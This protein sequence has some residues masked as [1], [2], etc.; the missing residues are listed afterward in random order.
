MQPELRTDFQFKILETLVEFRAFF[1]NQIYVGES[2]DHIERFFRQIWCAV[3]WRET[4]KA[5]DESI[6]LATLFRLDPGLLL[7]YDGELKDLRMPLLLKMLARVPPGIIFLPGPR[8]QEPGM[9]WGPQTWL[10]KNNGK[11]TQIEHFLREDQ[12]VPLLED[13]SL[14]VR[15]PGFVLAQAP[16][17]TRNPLLLTTVDLSNFWILQL[18][19]HND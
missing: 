13:G 5:A 9:G 19:D 10:T 7:S 1:A 3:Q 2:K 18:D 15:Y 16:R 17:V 11:G 6:C 14:L 8:L 4:T 12:L